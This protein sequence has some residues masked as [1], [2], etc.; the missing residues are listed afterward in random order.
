VW[1]RDAGQK[2]NGNLQQCG[3]SWDEACTPR[4]A[5]SSSGP[6]TA[7]AAALMVKCPVCEQIQICQP[8]AFLTQ[9]MV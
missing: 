5:S 8:G 6:L 2:A 9:L 4:E 1:A 7:A 3:R